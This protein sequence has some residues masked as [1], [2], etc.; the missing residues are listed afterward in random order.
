MKF[1]QQKA[2]NRRPYPSK[3]TTQEWCC[4]FSWKMSKDPT[5]QC[6]KNRTYRTSRNIIYRSAS[7]YCSTKSRTMTKRHGMW[8]PRS[9]FLDHT[10]K[11]ESNSA[12]SKAWDFDIPQSVLNDLQQFLS[13][14]FIWFP[15]NLY[16]H[17]L[18]RVV[19]PHVPR[20]RSPN[21]ASLVNGKHSGCPP[22]VC[23]DVCPP[24]NT[25]HALGR[26]NWTQLFIS[27]LFW[28]NSS[29]QRH[30][31]TAFWGICCRPPVT[32]MF[33]KQ[34]IA[35]FSSTVI[36]RSSNNSGWNRFSAPWQLCPPLAG[37]QSGKHSPWPQSSQKES[38]R[39]RSELDVLKANQHQFKQHRLCKQLQ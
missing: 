12:M 35:H 15:C 9:Q 19:S 16:G 29:S 8:P 13:D 10:G 21:K 25:N 34:H 23:L 36:C 11:S 22:G 30:R 3:D 26:S 4:S 33:G 38:Q 27:S 28:T 1:Q 17:N 24:A 7:F 14:G 37:R 20:C 6:W 32:W 31:S 2:M 5:I 39:V 18:F